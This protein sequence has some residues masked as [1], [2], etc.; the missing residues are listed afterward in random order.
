MRK[1]NQNFKSKRF[2]SFLT[3]VLRALQLSLSDNTKIVQIND[4]ETIKLYINFYKLLYLGTPFAEK[5]LNIKLEE[6][7][8]KSK[9]KGEQQEITK[10]EWDDEEL[11]GDSGSFI[12]DTSEMSS[13]DGGQGD[14]I[15]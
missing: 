11:K 4:T 12:I 14:G 7:K 8:V 9:K 5:M 1:I 2:I 3:T 10:Q 15:S 6:S 13:S